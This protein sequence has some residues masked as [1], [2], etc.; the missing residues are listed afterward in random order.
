M[1]CNILPRAACLSVGRR[2]GKR[3]AGKRFNSC[4]SYFAALSF[5]AVLQGCGPSLHELAVSAFENQ[6]KSYKTIGMI[7]PDVL[8]FELTTGGVTERIDEW[9]DAASKKF[10]EA[11]TKNLKSSQ[12]DVRLMEWR[13]ET[14][15][16]MEDVYYLFRAVSRSMR[17]NS[18]YR[19]LSDCG[20]EQT[21]RDFAVGPLDRLFAG[22][23]IDAVLLI[24]GWNEIESSGRTKARR[25]SKA[26]AFVSAF[27]PVRVEAVRNPGTFVSMALVDR[28]GTVLW[29]TNTL[30]GKGYDLRD[31]Q[32]VD[33]LT[34]QMIARLRVWT[35]R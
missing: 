19:K 18:T 3:M 28:N 10:F 12:V 22:Q 5:L 15:T 24:Y 13:K 8:L 25:A 16:E 34:R 26:V 17:L 23:N 21:C 14:E 30:T 6:V 29:S 31:A 4:F 32:G 7:P 1:L 33:E 2:E 35:D 20:D 9:S 27:G 11:A